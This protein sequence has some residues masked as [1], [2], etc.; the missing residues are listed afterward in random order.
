MNHD[1]RDRLETATRIT[2]G[3]EEALREKT[4]E[5][6]GTRDL[7]EAD[8]RTRVIWEWEDERGGAS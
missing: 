8:R 2:G 6:L 4:A 7:D 5:H 3:D 1:D